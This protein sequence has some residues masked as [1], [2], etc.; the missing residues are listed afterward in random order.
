MCSIPM[1][2]LL[3]QYCSASLYPILHTEARKPGP[4]PYLPRKL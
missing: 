4:V 2:M 1:C 3:Q